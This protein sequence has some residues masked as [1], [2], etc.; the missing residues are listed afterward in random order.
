MKDNG[1]FKRI[2][3]L[4]VKEHTS[5]NTVLPVNQPHKYA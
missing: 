3:Y 4:T 1:E 5:R 2:H